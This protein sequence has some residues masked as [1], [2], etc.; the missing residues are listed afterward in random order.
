M[1]FIAAGGL[2]GLI[3]DG[4]SGGFFVAE[5]ALVLCSS[6]LGVNVEGSGVAGGDVRGD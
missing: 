2:A 6:S 1:N 4:A 5:V 3:D